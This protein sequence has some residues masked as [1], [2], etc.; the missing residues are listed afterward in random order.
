M[1][2]HGWIAQLTK[3]NFF[4]YGTPRFGVGVAADRLDGDGYDEILTGAGP[5]AVFGPHVR[6]FDYDAT[7]IAAMGKVSFY[8][9]ATVR[10]GV[11]VSDGDVDGDG[12]G[13]ILTGPGPAAAFTPLL[14]AFDVDGGAVT[15]ISRINAWAF[16][17]ARY[18]LHVA[19]GDLET[20]GYDEIACGAGPDPGFGS[21]LRAFDYDGAALAEIPALSLDPFGL[22][23]GL[24]V[25]AGGLG[26]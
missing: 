8:A 23:Y 1:N 15:P 19:G 9:Y 6:G 26:L 20:D 11:T 22:S 14:R 5:G 16:T 3:V 12:F 4:A 25:A 7:A 24:R 10:Y 13:E 17:G 2:R 21:E 18:G